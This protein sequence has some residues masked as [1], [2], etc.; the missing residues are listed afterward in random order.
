MFMIVTAPWPVPSANAELAKL[1]TAGAATHIPAA[2]AETGTVRPG[3]VEALVC[4]NR[5]ERLRLLWYRFR[6]TTGGI[7]RTSAAGEQRLKLR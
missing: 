3:Q 1:V 4:W 5:R 6:L 2:V 7:H